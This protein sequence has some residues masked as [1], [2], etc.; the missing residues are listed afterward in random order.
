MCVSSEQAQV[1]ADIEATRKEQKLLVQKITD[2]S[3]GPDGCGPQLLQS[4]L[5]LKDDS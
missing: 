5:T 4:F 3:G 1:E 2:K